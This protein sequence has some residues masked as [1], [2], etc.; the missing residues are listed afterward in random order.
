VTLSG[1]TAGTVGSVYT[2]SAV[3]DV[4][5]LSSASVEPSANLPVTFT[6]QAT[7]QSAIV[8]TGS[9]TDEVSFTWTTVGEKSVLVTVTNGD[10]EATDE[11][12][13][14]ITAAVPAS[15]AV[16]A[17]PEIIPADGT[18]T[19]T[20]MATVKD[21]LG[22]AIAN[23]KVDFSSDVGVITV[24]AMTDENGEAKATLTSATTVT[25]ATVTATAGGISADVEVVF[26]SATIQGGATIQG[27]VFK[28]TNHNGTQQSGEPGIAGVKVTVTPGAGVH[29]DAVSLAAVDDVAQ[30]T[31]VTDG[32]GR[33]SVANL[34]LGEYQI[35]IE[36]PAGSRFTTPSTF[37]V[38]LDAMEVISFNAGIGIMISLPT[39]KK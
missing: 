38:T 39:L 16:T 17:A 31:V 25:T 24:S 34:P 21:A 28:D 1:Q 3:V 27:V 8:H 30:Q 14:T 5:L 15:V 12:K 23:Q 10:A 11:H 20:I 26:S 36:R 35:S 22:V 32:N 29:Q 13:I 33:Y 7:N 9:T 37:T 6:W 2:F 18:S 4:A 19:S